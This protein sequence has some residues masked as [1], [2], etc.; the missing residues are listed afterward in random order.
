MARSGNIFICYRREGTAAEAGRIYDHLARRIPRRRL[1]MDVDAIAPGLDFASEIEAQVASCSALLA[2]I[3]PGWSGAAD[4]A[5]ARRLEQP[6]DYVRLEI[7]HALARGITVVPVLVAGAR[8]PAES[9]LP[10]PLRTLARRQAIEIRHAS[11]AA[12]AERLTNAVLRVARG[13]LLASRRRLAAA[14]IAVALAASALLATWQVRAPQPDRWLPAIFRPSDQAPAALTGGGG[15]G[16]R[17][18]QA[19]GNRVALPCDRLAASRFDPNAVGP[20]VPSSELDAAKAVPACEMDVA[21]FPSLP[22]LRFQLANAYYTAGRRN[23]AARIYQELDAAG[24]VPATACLGLMHAQGFGVEQSQSRAEQLYRRSAAEGYAPAMEHLAGLLVDQ[25]P[26]P[27]RDAEAV[28]LYEAATRKGYEKA[29]L[30]LGRLYAIGRGASRNPVKAA[31][32]VL[33]SIKLG[34]KPAI[35]ELTEHPDDWDA[36]F[37]KA[38]QEQLRDLQLYRGAI[39]GRLGDDVAAALN[40]LYVQSRGLRLRARSIELPR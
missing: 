13:G 34:Y 23:E 32:L 26:D 20:G 29:Y 8:M 17:A 25:P 9:E 5:G 14:L 24:Y 16:G 35:G 28:A 22:R 3:G 39:D 30:F 15:G 37:R 27:A 1:F 33:R 40:E 19:E 36:D 12:D 2:I 6:N 31:Q 7:A 18:P 4:A 11:F 10:E 38:V 21:R